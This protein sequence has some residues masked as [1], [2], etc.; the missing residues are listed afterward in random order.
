MLKPGD[1]VVVDFAGA[2]GVKRRPAIVLSSDLY[3]THHPDVVLGVVTTQ[4]G[5]A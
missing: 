2:M 5:S 3:H 4:V 1:M